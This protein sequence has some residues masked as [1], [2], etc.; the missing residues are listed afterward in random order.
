MG[1]AI[2]GRAINQVLADAVAAGHVPRVAAIVADRDGILCEGGAGVRIA[3]ES[4]DPVT[5]STQFRIM[6]MTKM[7][8]TVAALQQ[9]ERGELDLD[10]PVDSYC[11]EFADVVVLEGRPCKPLT[12]GPSSGSSPT[13][14][15]RRTCRMSTRSTWSGVHHSTL[16]T[17][18]DT[19]TATVGFDPLDGIGRNR[20]GLAYL[21]QRLRNSRVLDLP[22]PAYSTSRTS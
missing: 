11:P 14:P 5:T 4:D 22:A 3:R 6:S 12:I 15:T 1:T 13:C 21:V 8:C 2:N 17:R 18:L 7:V 9:I 19:I 20:L 10:A 16:R